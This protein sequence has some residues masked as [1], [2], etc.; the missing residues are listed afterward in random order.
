MT[1]I[2]RRGLVVLLL[3]TPGSA[4]AAD[5]IAVVATVPDLADL[6]RTVGGDAVEVEALVRGPQDPHFIE[7]RPSF[8]R[9]LHDADLFVEVG[10]DLEVGWSPVLLRSARNPRILPGGEG[11]VDASTAIAPLE[12]PTGAVD[13]S[14]GD[15][16][17]YGNPHYLL[18]PL[19]GLRVARL[20]R[21]RL[22]ALRPE[23]SADFAART[24]RFEQA[25]VSALVGAS[26]AARHD[27][28]ELVARIDDGTLDAFLA[29]HGEADALGGWLGALRPY[30]GTEVIQDHRI[31]P[32]FARRFGLVPVMELE[33]KPGIAPTTAHVA[34]VIERVRAGH[35]PLLLTTPY[36]DARHARRVAEATGATVVELAHQV[37]A[38]ED[39]DGYQAMIDAN[40]R[41]VEAA[42]SDPIAEEGA[43]AA[44]DADAKRSRETP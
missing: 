26:L 33:P 36:F 37:G 32:Y 42:L 20:L 43:P 1:R 22:S 29:G 44:N 10:L 19:N 18:D 25:L 35:V 8:V 4:W 38:R 23:A 34:R 9:R 13:R 27:P 11:Y 6:V 14:M 12:V 16:H 15:V 17:P 5:R 31:F 30:R 2:L 24:D 28:A 39:T 40:V 41:G 21:D 3:L 7:P